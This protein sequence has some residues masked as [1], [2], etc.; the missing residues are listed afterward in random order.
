MF[1]PSR[2]N[3]SVMPTTS[4]VRLRGHQPLRLTTQPLLPRAYRY[5]T[6]LPPA[7]YWYTGIHGRRAA[8]RRRQL[9]HVMVG[10]V[11]PSCDRPTTTLLLA[12]MHRTI[13]RSYTIPVRTYGILRCICRSMFFLKKIKINFYSSL[14]HSC[15]EQIAFSLHNINYPFINI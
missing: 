1:H 10:V 2:A 6:Y 11:V 3:P 12:A 7:V 13:R 4:C 8:R 9:Q 5:H 15:N 14:A